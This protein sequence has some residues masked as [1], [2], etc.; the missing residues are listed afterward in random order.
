L[1]GVKK[2]FFRVKTFNGVYWLPA[3][4]T[5]VSHIRPVA[6]EY[7]IK[8]ALTILRKPPNALAKDYKRRGKEIS[9]VLEDCTLYAKAHV[10]RD[11]HGRK[12]TSSI[13]Q[14]EVALLDKLKK[15][16]LHE[17]A[18]VTSKENKV[19]EDKL[20]QALKTS[21]EK[22]SSMEADEDTEGD[23][24]LDKVRKG[25]KGIRKSIN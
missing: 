19:L 15:E 6:S 24:W 14:T 5:E 3:K 22:F 17:W 11:L 21:M 1:E 8:K 23:S 10:I 25:A 16:F 20:D 4:N 9:H 7:Q 12:M 2:M 13:N 18:I